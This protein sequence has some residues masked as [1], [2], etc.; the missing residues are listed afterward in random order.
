MTQCH[1]KAVS[2]STIFGLSENEAMV[3]VSSILTLQ[4]NIILISIDNNNVINK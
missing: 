2:H 3:Y 4:R 1:D